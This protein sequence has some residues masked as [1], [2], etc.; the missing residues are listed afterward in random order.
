MERF[1]F[2]ANVYEQYGAMMHFRDNDTSTA[3]NGGLIEKMV[4]LQCG[5]VMRPVTCLYIKKFAYQ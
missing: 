2:R 3:N 5:Q 1:D 4:R